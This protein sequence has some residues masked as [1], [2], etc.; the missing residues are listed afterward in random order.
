[1]FDVGI[2]GMGV[3]G[4]FCAYK[5]AEQQK[6]IKILGIELGRPP[7]KRHELMGGLDAYPIQMANYIL[8]M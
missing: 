5:L 6:D 2:I 4:V 7:G 8:M 3:G 1:M